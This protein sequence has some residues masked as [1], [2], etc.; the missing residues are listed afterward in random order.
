MN[1]VED[2][3]HQSVSQEWWSKSQK[4]IRCFDNFFGF[5]DKL[6][7][8]PP[9]NDLVGS[10]PENHMPQEQA[11]SYYGFIVYMSRTYRGMMPYLKGIHLT[12]ASWRVYCDYEGW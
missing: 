5:F 9:I 11:E 8:E 4:K 6:A 2:V 10:F 7:E 3:P 1:T 12:L